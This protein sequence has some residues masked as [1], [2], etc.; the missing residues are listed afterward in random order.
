MIFTA[1]TAVRLER[2]GEAIHWSQAAIRADA[3]RT[4]VDG[5]GYRL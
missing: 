3:Q 2:H 1:E 5:A 4:G